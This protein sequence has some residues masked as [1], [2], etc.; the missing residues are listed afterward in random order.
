[1]TVRIGSPATAATASI[2]V[3]RLGLHHLASGHRDIEHDLRLRDLRLETSQPHASKI[4]RKRSTPQ[5]WR[6]RVRLE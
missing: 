5:R 4:R 1:M 3:S 6:I 2:C